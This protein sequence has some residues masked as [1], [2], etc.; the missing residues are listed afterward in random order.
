MSS[1]P[2]RVLVIGLSLAC[3]LAS[4]G[5]AQVAP[6]W[7]PLTNPAPGGSVITMM[8]LSD[9]SVLPRAATTPSTGSSSPPTPTAAM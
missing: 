1:H 7:A 9:G 5:F 4:P 3:G 6:S 8:L 2:V